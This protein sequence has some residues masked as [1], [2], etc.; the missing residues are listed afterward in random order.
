[1]DVAPVDRD[2]N[3]INN[4]LSTLINSARMDSAGNL[5]NKNVL[6]E[7]FYREFLNILYGWKLVNANAERQ[8]MPGIDL[9]DQENRVVAQVSATCTHRKIQGSLDKFTPPDDSSW[10]FVFIPIKPEVTKPE[11]TFNIRQ[12]VT[13]DP[14]SDILD[15]KALL[16]KVQHADNEVKLCLVRFLQLEKVSLWNDLNQRLRE[17]R[18]NHP[19]FMLMAPDELDKQLYPHIKD[20]PALLDAYGKNS[21][22]EVCL[23]WEIIRASWREPENRPIVIEGAGGIGKTVALFSI[24]DAEDR[25]CPAP[26]IYVPMHRLVKQD[27]RTVDLFNFFQ[28]I[29][30][31]I[32]ALAKK[33]WDGGP[34]LLVLLDGFNEVP[35]A[36]Q[37]DILEKLKDWHEH[38]QGAQFIAV[39]RPVDT[40][41]L[42]QELS[43]NTI[44]IELQP[45]ER[46]TARAYLIE[47]G[48]MPPADEAEIW[49]TLVLPLFLTLYVKTDGLATQTASGYPLAVKP[50]ESNGALI[51]NYL[52]RELLR[53]KN[54]G[55]SSETWVM[56]CAIACEYILPY[57]AFRMEREHRFTLQRKEARALIKEV[58]DTLD[59]EKLPRHLTALANIYDDTNDFSDLRQLEWSNTVLHDIGILIK[60]KKS[61]DIYT[62]VHQHFRDALAGLYL[63]N[64][65]E[66][67]RNGEALPEVWRRAANY[68]VMSYA[69]GL[70][71]EPE[72]ARLWEANRLMRPTDSSATYAMLELQMRRSD[73][74][75]SKLD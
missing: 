43:K 46:E 54:S 34:Q 63:V 6:M 11:N 37:R 75:D 68:D 30:P 74:S 47:R 39:S 55:E 59:M 8:N 4:A 60:D 31:Q 45:I 12:N 23:I 1:M 42:G 61:N 71:E 13:F 62:F 10:H 53:K 41:N 49:N 22:G 21:E 33:P 58:L 17:T 18:D 38:H 5:Q 40:V 50:P 51:W 69:A 66:M 72:A 48:I 70:M 36:K 56:R 24:A 57:I 27:G 19:S 20:A 29:S 32:D 64:Q 28:K 14:Q 67:M 44:S 25:Y 65:A 16:E 2:Y 26:A 52:Q 9:I 7:G 15:G 73:G 35:A 3:T